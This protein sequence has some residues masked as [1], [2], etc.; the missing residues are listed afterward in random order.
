MTTPKD[1]AELIAYGAGAFVYSRGR[2]SRHTLGEQ[3]FKAALAA[4]E[5]AG[6]RVEMRD[7]VDLDRLDRALHDL[8]T[9]QPKE[10]KQWCRDLILMYLSTS[11]YAPEREDG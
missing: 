11:P 3:A 10:S 4:I 7:I 2:T 5:A 1:R 9:P 6:W 8:G